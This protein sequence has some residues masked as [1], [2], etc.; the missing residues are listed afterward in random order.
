MTEPWFPNNVPPNYCSFKSYFKKRDKQASDETNHLPRSRGS[1]LPLKFNQY[2]FFK[3]I[4]MIPS[5]KDIK[6]LKEG[7]VNPNKTVR[8]HLSIHTLLHCYLWINPYFI[9]KRGNLDSLYWVTV[10]PTRGH[11]SWRRKAQRWWS[12]GLVPAL[13]ESK[14]TLCKCTQSCLHTGKSPIGALLKT[15]PIIKWPC[16]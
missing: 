14:L 2:Y 9:F 3:S 8:G 10:T 5:T 16:L 15:H 12:S 1:S 4:W 6:I 7:K 13:K 11:F